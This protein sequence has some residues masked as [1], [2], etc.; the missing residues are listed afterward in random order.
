MYTDNSEDGLATILIDS[1]A[2][3]WQKVLLHSGASDSIL[4]SCEVQGPEWAVQGVSI[5]GNASL[6]FWL[7][8]IKSGRARKLNAIKVKRTFKGVYFCLSLHTF[9]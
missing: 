5:T 9:V 4:L 6:S 2:T 3:N 7:Y 1:S 8:A